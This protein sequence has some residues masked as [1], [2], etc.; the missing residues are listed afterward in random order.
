[1]QLERAK[2]SLQAVQL[3]ERHGHLAGDAGDEKKGPQR[4]WW[5]LLGHLARRWAGPGC[6]RPSRSRA[7][8]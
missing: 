1:L 5:S 2:G 7:A 4:R 6:T 8:L 3:D